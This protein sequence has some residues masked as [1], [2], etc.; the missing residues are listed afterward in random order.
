MRALFEQSLA[1]IK[2][3]LSTHATSFLHDVSLLPPTDNLLA[4][5]AEALEAVCGNFSHFSDFQELRALPDAVLVDI[6]KSDDLHVRD[7][8]N[9]V[10]DFLRAHY[11]QEDRSTTLLGKRKSAGSNSAVNSGYDEVAAEQDDGSHAQSIAMAWSTCRLAFVSCDRL[12]RLKMRGKL[13]TNDLSQSVADSVHYRDILCHASPY[14]RSSPLKDFV[15]QHSAT[16]WCQPRR[17]IHIPPPKQNEVDFVVHIPRDDSFLER[18]SQI[19]SQPV[20][21]EDTAVALRVFPVGT[22]STAELERPVVSLFL[23]VTPAEKIGHSNWAFKRHY[24]IS[25]YP[26]VA[27]QAPKER[28]DT[29][30]FSAERDDRGWHD[31]FDD[32]VAGETYTHQRSEKFHNSRLAAFEY[33][34][35]YNLLW[36]R[37]RVSEADPS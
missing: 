29:H 21:M 20:I 2:A 26:W 16:A 4:I 37:G 11:I 13:G 18:G 14:C 9:D 25:V 3:K 32:V 15:T 27:G 31:F 35:E 7:G 1:D 17:P 36:V 30:I 22:V 34:N 12:M 28:V 19:D 33:C 6:L 24:S 8:E 10:F 23:A 5:K